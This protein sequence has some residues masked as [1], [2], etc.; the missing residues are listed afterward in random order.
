MYPFVGLSGRDLETIPGFLVESGVKLEE[1]RDLLES[2]PY[3]ALLRLSSYYPEIWAIPKQFEAIQDEIEGPGPLM[4]LH[5]LLGESKEV[6]KRHDN[7]VA[8]PHRKWGGGQWST[9]NCMKLYKMKPPHDFQKEERK[10]YSILGTI[11]ATLGYIKSI[12][13]TSSLIEQHVLLSKDYLIFSDSQ[14]ASWI[15]EQLFGTYPELLKVVSGLPFYLWLHLHSGGLDRN[16]ASVKETGKVNW[17]DH[18]LV[19]KYR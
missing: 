18:D 11:Y 7:L 15:A 3:S 17:I 1:F 13:F 9:G 4:K 5:C 14:T 12:T 16:P 2:I 10:I 6:K 19:F 8:D